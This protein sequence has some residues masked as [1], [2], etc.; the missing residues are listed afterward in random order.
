MLAEGTTSGPS[1]D[2]LFLPKDRKPSYITGS[3]KAMIQEK[4]KEKHDLK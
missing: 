2:E 4:M 3:L 1:V